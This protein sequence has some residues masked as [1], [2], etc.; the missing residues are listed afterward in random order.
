MASL[1]EYLGSRKTSLRPDR[2]MRKMGARNRLYTIAKLA[3]LLRRI[4]TGEGEETV[5]QAYCAVRSTSPSP[6]KSAQ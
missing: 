5:Q 4:T 1:L 2:R 3:P 6:S